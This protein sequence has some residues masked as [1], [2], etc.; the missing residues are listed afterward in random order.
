MKI[1]PAIAVGVAMAVL[2]TNARSM[3]AT[4]KDY[5]GQALDAKDFKDGN[6]N[7]AKFDGASLKGADFRD[8]NLEGADFTGAELKGA[9]FHNTK[10]WHANF[11]GSELELVGA[12]MPDFSKIDDYRA[13]QTLMSN[14]EH[15]NGTLSFHYADLH[16]ALILG[17]AKDVDFRNAD[18]R[19]ADLSKVTRLKEA[20]LG[21]AKYDENTNWKID[22]KEAGAEFVPATAK[23]G[24]AVA[25]KNPLIGKWLVLKGE[26]D[27][28]DNG[29]LRILADHTFEWDPA[30]AADKPKVLTGKWAEA[31]ESIELKGGELGQ[32]WTAGKVAHNGKPE[33]QLQSEKGIK[34]VAVPE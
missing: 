5:T 22:P 20:R 10:A 23:P 14:M 21:K 11:A 18:L 26:G 30:L 19:G 15:D 4:V 32:S 6:L 25:A 2:L 8:S 12:V 24:D 16:N 29:V 34:R 3:A 27:A 17:D 13:R 33:M 9:K 7:E 28:P 31:G 1:N